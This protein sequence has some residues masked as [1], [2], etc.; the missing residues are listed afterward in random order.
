LT[1]VRVNDVRYELHS[2]FVPAKY[3]VGLQQATIDIADGIPYSSLLYYN[4]FY[5]LNTKNFKTGFM[6]NPKIGSNEL[7]VNAFIGDIKGDVGVWLGADRKTK[8]E[9]NVV[10]P[11][12]DLIYTDWNADTKTNEI[13]A[14]A[15]SVPNDDKKHLKGFESDP[16]ASPYNATAK[17]NNYENNCKDLLKIIVKNKLEKS[18]ELLLKITD[19]A[20]TFVA[21]IFNDLNFST[22][23]L[24]SNTRA[25]ILPSDSNIDEIS[26]YLMGHRLYT[27]TPL[28]SPFMKEY[29][30]IAPNKIEKKHNVKISCTRG[31]RGYNLPYMTGDGNPFTKIRNYEDN[32]QFLKI[33]DENANRTNGY[34]SIEG[35]DTFTDQ[36]EASD[37]FKSKLL[38]IL[39]SVIANAY[40]LSD[41]CDEVLKELGDTPVYFE[42]YENSIENYQLRN[43]NDQFMPL[44]LALWFMNDN[45]SLSESHN[46]GPTHILF[47]GHNLGTNDFK[48]LYGTRQLLARNMALTYEELPGVKTII[49]RHNASASEKPI[50]ESRY[51]QFVNRLITGLRFVVNSHGYKRIVAHNSSGIKVAGNFWENQNDCGVW[52]TGTH[53]FVSTDKNDLLHYSTNIDNT[54]VVYALAG[55]KMKKELILQILEDSYQE[56]SV[57]KIL[58]C[59]Y[60]SENAKSI[61]RKEERIKVIIDSNINPINVH[62][63]MQDIPLANIYNYAYTFENMTASM[64]GM[65]MSKISH[66]TDES[67]HPLKRTITE[68]LRLLRT[69]FAPVKIEYFKQ[70]FTHSDNPLFNIFTGDGSLGMGRPKFLSDQLFNKCLLCNIYY[71]NTEPRS[72]GSLENNH[73]YDNYL[74]NLISKLKWPPFLLPRDM[75]RDPRIIDPSVLKLVTEF[76]NRDEPFDQAN[77]QF[78][79]YN[80]SIIAAI[81]ASH[82]ILNATFNQD[83]TN[84]PVFNFILGNNTIGTDVPDNRTADIVAYKNRVIYSTG[85]IYGNNATYGGSSVVDKADGRTRLNP[86]VGDESKAKEFADLIRASVFYAST[87]ANYEAT[88]GDIKALFMFEDMFEA[89]IRGNP[90]FLH[91]KNELK[92]FWEQLVSK[93]LNRLIIEVYMYALSNNN[94][95]KAYIIS[96]QRSQVQNYI[97]KSFCDAADVSTNSIDYYSSKYI[98]N[99]EIKSNLITELTRK[100]DTI[101]FRKN[102]IPR[103]QN[104]TLV[105]SYLK[106]YSYYNDKD[107]TTPGVNSKSNPLVIY[108]YET[109]NKETERLESFLAITG[110]TR[111]NTNVVRN[112]FF[113]SN[114]LRIIRLQ[115]NREFTQNRN[116]LKS[117]HFAIS[118]S[119][120][121]YGMMDPNEVFESRYR[122]A[123]MF[124]DS[125]ENYGDNGVQFEDEVE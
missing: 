101:N 112:L 48:M 33:T 110:Y 24:E 31:T 21:Q 77:T 22:H 73:I 5:W 113:I 100:A 120:T 3:L 85:E 44:S 116:I 66:N 16:T 80:R 82:I 89:S 81:D 71:D 11:I 56:N 79:A 52:L 38:S 118:P 91:I 54:N 39:D 64:Y 99:D 36:N 104:T 78:V 95:N 30:A 97:D 7:E 108:K 59:F 88:E 103:K 109:G 17:Y 124:N 32:S 12:V 105:M 13:S 75:L 125:I 10:T 94:T 2:Y 14:Y 122:G 57:N 76:L 1:D 28:V 117:S 84:K 98:W 86:I 114:V 34:I 35:L 42:T 115:I 60:L 8:F 65:I 18:F 107:F 83:D 70:F 55:G 26:T 19:N 46:M 41:C 9:T 121:E 72:R 93:I 96:N 27:A 119:V 90:N 6:T 37:D 53:Q 45:Y 67:G 61:T 123:R 58:R 15:V 47:S 74:P 4:Y 62:A 63:L 51:L 87:G 68:F 92:G 25:A 43:N 20:D 40:A 111:F 23:L 106:E 50:E 102:P 29:D 69:P 49:N